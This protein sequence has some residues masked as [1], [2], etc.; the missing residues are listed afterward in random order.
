MIQSAAA[1]TAQT[2]RI[3]SLSCAAPPREVL[4]DTAAAPPTCR[5]ASLRRAAIPVRA[6]YVKAHAALGG[7]SI[8]LA[9]G[10]AIIA[11]ERK[12]GA[13]VID[14]ICKTMNGRHHREGQGR[15]QGGQYT[16]R[17]FRHRHASRSAAGASELVLHVMNEYMAV[18]D[19]SGR[20]LASIPR[21]DHH[22]R[23]RT[24]C[25]SS[26]G[27]DQGRHGA[28]RAAHSQGRASPLSPPA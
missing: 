28:V 23:P 10:E 2:T 24:G 9:L 19:A 5:A 26:V 21:C 6:S 27:R 20:R 3:S 22:A 8:A 11:A 15:A 13:A 17:S 18:E 4:A 16:E 25:R 12:G 14:A 1:A 7:I